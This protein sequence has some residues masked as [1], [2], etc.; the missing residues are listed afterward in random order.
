MARQVM[1]VPG[2]VLNGVM[3]RGAKGL[4]SKALN[5]IPGILTKGIPFLIVAEVVGQS[6]NATP[7]K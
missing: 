2:R 6:D 3:P 5:M 4:P 7:T 1:N